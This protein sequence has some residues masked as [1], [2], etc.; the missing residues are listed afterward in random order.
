M[1]CKAL[2]NVISMFYNLSQMKEKSFLSTIVLLLMLSLFLF[3]PYSFC[4]PILLDRVVAVVNKDIITWSDLYKWME[5][6]STDQLKTMDEEQR[7]KIF[8]ENEETYLKKLIDIKLQLQEANRLG[9]DVTPEEVK[10]AI[11]NIKMKYSLSDEALKESL[12][13]EGF[14]FEEYKNRLR[15]QIIIGKLINLQI[16]SK[17]VVSDEEVE[18]HTDNKNE[19]A[20]GNDEFKLRQIFFKKPMDDDQKKAIEDKAQLIIQKLKQ[21]EDFSALASEYSEDPTGKVGGDLGY[22]KK[23]YLAKEFVN[24]LSSMKIGDFSMPFWTEKGLHIIKL[25]DKRSARTKEEVKEE[26]RRKLSETKF[27]ERYENWMEDLRNNAHIVI[28]L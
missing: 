21:S 16:R 3:V 12:K 27:L 13:K 24:T 2:R 11:E 25:E 18:K 23:N 5:Q 8:K 6:D 7:R 15:E 28:S 17:V 10:E 14:D 20:I 26:I 1:E 19:D 9:I 22:V 4:E